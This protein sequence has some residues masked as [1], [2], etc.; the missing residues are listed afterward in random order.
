MQQLSAADL[1]R[2]A[3][4]LQCQPGDFIENDGRPEGRKYADPDILK[5]GVTPLRGKPSPTPESLV[6]VDPF[7]GENPATPP[8]E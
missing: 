4:A 3:F 8:I 1:A 7:C 2:L 6:S 5:F